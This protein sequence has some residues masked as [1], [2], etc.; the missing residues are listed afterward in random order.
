MKI[1]RLIISKKENYESDLDS[2]KED[3]KNYQ[4]P[5]EFENAYTQSHLT[6]LSNREKHRIGR[7][8]DENDSIASIVNGNQQGYLEDIRTSVPR[9]YSAIMA[10]KQS[11]YITV[12]RAVPP[13]TEQIISFLQ[14]EKNKVMKYGNRVNYT[15][16]E[17]MNIQDDSRQKSKY[18]EFLSDELDNLISGKSRFENIKDNAIK[19]GDYVALDKSYAVMHGE[20]L[21]VWGQRYPTYKIVSKRIP[22]SDVIWGQADWNEWT[23]SPQSIRQE[24]P[25]GLKDIY[26]KHRSI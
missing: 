21:I 6:D 17:I 7:L 9:A 13:T 1:Y 12:Y 25:M 11:G 24:Y 18:Y 23:Y 8:F 10:S 16:Q 14:S 19:I 2:V 20:S 26:K 3:I 4:S 5:E 15:Y 22:I